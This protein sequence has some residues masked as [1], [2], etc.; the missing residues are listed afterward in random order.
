MTFGMKY[1]LD[2][3]VNTDQSLWDSG[4]FVSL[5]LFPFFIRQIVNDSRIYSQNDYVLALTPTIIR[6]FGAVFQ[7]YAVQYGNAGPV[8]AIQNSKNII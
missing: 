7:G 6:N 3:G 2:V 5:M 1:S 4:L 8:D